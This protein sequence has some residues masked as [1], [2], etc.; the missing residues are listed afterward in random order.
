[1]S[2]TVFVVLVFSVFFAVMFKKNILNYMM[3][4]M[5]ICHNNSDR[6]CSCPGTVGCY[7]KKLMHG[8]E[9]MKEKDDGVLSV[10]TID[11]MKYFLASNDE[12]ENILRYSP[13]PLQDT[14]PKDFA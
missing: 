9:S 6:C 13:T 8:N 7:D 10:E 12:K 5:A 4:V 14:D 3:N 11:K 1:M 2:G